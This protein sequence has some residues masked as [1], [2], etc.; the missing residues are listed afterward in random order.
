M[1]TGTITQ[2][3]GPVVDVHFEEGVPEILNALIVD[4]DDKKG[5]TLEVAQHIGT[6][7]VR[8][9]ALEDTQG[10]TRGLSVTDTGAPI[11]VP[12]GEQSL[13]RLFNVLGS[14]LD[15]KGNLD[16]GK[17][18]AIH[19]PAPAF[20]EQA[21]N[22]EVFETGIKAVDLLAPFIKGGKVG[23]SAKVGW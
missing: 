13:G 15:G 2:I 20:T 4:T 12:V 22:T 17:K 21:T 11:S 18:R 16:S 8:A 7:R 10:L 23:L 19:Q 9:I 14:T 3:I 1:K 5:L 6:D